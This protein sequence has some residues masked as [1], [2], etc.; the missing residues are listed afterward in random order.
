MIENDFS[1][2][3]WGKCSSNNRLHYEN[4]QI[5]SNDVMTPLSMKHKMLP[6][7]NQKLEMIGRDIWCGYGLEKRV[8]IGGIKFSLFFGLARSY[9]IQIPLPVIKHAV[10][11]K[12]K[13]CGMPRHNM[14]MGD[15]AIS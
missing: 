10:R 12:L 8:K 7:R 13:L 3:A 6:L 9:Y 14:R 4:P 2:K 11:S 5:R 1:A 15:P